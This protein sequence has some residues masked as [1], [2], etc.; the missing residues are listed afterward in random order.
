LVVADGRWGGVISTPRPRRRRLP[1]R[2]LPFGC[3]L[4]RMPT[5]APIAADPAA[6]PDRGARRPAVPVPIALIGQSNPIAPERVTAYGSMAASWPLV[7]RPMA[8]S[9]S[10]TA[11][12][13]EPTA[14]SWRHLLGG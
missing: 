4:D 14:G 2:G 1:Q 6:A 9:P 13:A 5:A 8:A 3:S 7:E 10:S 11:A 12:A